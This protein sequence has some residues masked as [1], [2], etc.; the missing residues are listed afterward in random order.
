MKKYKFLI[1]TLLV[2]LYIFACSDDIGNY[3]YN[4]DVNMLEVELSRTFNILKKDGEFVIRPTIRQTDRANNDNL[5]YIW[6]MSTKNANDLGGAITGDTISVADTVSIIID[7]QDPDFAYNYWLRFYVEDVVTGAKAMYPT[8]LSIIKPYEGAWMVLHKDEGVTKLGSIEYL[9]DAEMV[10]TQDAFFEERGV[11]LVGEPQKLGVLTDGIGS[12]SPY[13]PYWGYSA[14]TIFYCFTDQYNESG[15]YRPENGFKLIDEN[16]TVR[17]MLG[18]GSDFSNYSAPGGVT[19]VEG[20]SALLLIGAGGT[21]AFQ[22]SALGPKCYGLTLASGVPGPFRIT[23]ASTFV[24][25]LFFDAE[26]RRFL[27]CNLSSNTWYPVPSN[28][29]AFRWMFLGPSM[30][31]ARGTLANIQDLPGNALPIEELNDIGTDKDMVYIGT[32]YY[33]GRGVMTGGGM[34]TALYALAKSN[35]TNESYI[36]EF[37]GYPILLGSSDANDAAPLFDFHT[38]TTPS[39]LTA[40]TPCA[41]S[42]EYNKIIFYAVGD[43]VYRLDFGATGGRTQLIWQHPNGTANAK[44]MQ[45]ARSYNVSYPANFVKYGHNLNRSLGIVFETSGG[46]DEVVVLNLNASG[47]VAMDGEYPSVQIHQGFGRIKD[48]AF[49]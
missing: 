17:D 16:R 9:G 2:G 36:Y 12:G 13:E 40:T 37:H 10:I 3:K 20:G 45:M 30:D 6:R 19:Y 27:W 15:I 48:I 24:G 1:V 22:G 7:T 28:P 21:A 31:Q 44:S 8:M 35:R 41:S 46:R 43:K 18:Y 39:G 23:H 38:I 49:I 5:R 42:V 4:E 29:A 32:G 11:H 47:N 26:Y 25:H 34:R 14:S 33:Y